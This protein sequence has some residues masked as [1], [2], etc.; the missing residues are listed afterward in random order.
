MGISELELCSPATETAEAGSGH[1]VAVV[2]QLRATHTEHERTRRG[3]GERTTC[4][5]KNFWTRPPAMQARDEQSVN[6]YTL[7]QRRQI[8]TA[9]DD[10]RQQANSVRVRPTSST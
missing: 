2:R 7:V 10:Q 9:K 4:S 8:G 6:L 1:D 3:Q 5:N